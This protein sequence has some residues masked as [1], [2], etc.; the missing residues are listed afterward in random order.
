MSQ[1][2]FSPFSVALIFHQFLVLRMVESDRCAKPS[3]PHP[4]D[5]Q[6]HSRLNSVVANLYVKMINNRCCDI[7]EACRNNA[8]HQRQ[9]LFWPVSVSLHPFWFVSSE[10][11][12]WLPRSNRSAPPTSCPLP[13]TATRRPHC[14]T[15]WP[16]WLPSAKAWPR[17]R[18]SSTDSCCR[19]VA[20]G[21]SAAE[22]RHQTPAN[23]LNWRSH[24]HLQAEAQKAE[25]AKLRRDAET[26]RAAAR[27]EAA[28]L[29]QDVMRLLGDK[30]AQESSQRYLQELL[31]RLEAELSALQREKA[32]E[33]LEQQSQVGSQLL[34]LGEPHQARQ[35]L[36]A[37]AR[38]SSHQ[39]TF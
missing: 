16:R 31:Q 10:L 12:V 6:W 7:A 20:V 9:L 37:P 35:R 21:Q 4:K 19:S 27:E 15:P 5:S 2:F 24:V 11:C 13:S 39:G 14:R 17:T 22:L 34:P 28:G 30:Q 33:V 1:E 38:S 8:C 25:L 32:A 23:L 36:S 29:Q 3:L 18:W 26:E